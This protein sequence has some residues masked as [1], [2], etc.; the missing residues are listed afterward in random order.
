MTARGLGGRAAVVAAVLV[1]GG[2]ESQAGGVERKSFGT[3]PLG[4]TV[5]LF[6][7]KNGKGVTATIMGWGGIVVSLTAPDREGRLADIVLGFDT[8]A[9]YLQAHPYFGALV[10][11]YGN[12]IAGG[13][14]RLDGEVH[15]LPKNN[16]ENTL[17]GG[18]ES[19]GKK[20]WSIREVPAADGAAL[21]LAYTSPDGEEGF[22]GTLKTRVTYTLTD[23]S[24]LRIDYE[25]TTDKPT[26]V[27][28]TNHSY[29]NLAGPGSGDILGHVL[30]IDADRFTPVGEGPHPHGR[31]ARRRGHAVRL[32]HPHPDRGPHRRPGP[33][34]PARGRVR[35][36]LRA[37]REGGHAAAC[38]PGE[39]APLRPRAGGA[40]H[41][42]GRPALHGQLPR[43]LRRRQGRAG[44][45]PA[46]GILPGDPALPGL[47]E[48]GRLSFHR[49]AARG[50]LPVDHRL[51]PDH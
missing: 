21:E 13:E 2:P 3:T 22:P 48:P 29:F 8:L 9:P 25:A 51:P 31:A 38:G 16:G 7:L 20:L 28:L 46:Y 15:H 1:L 14:F 35:P 41:R 12:R 24:E 30:R 43:R 10:G 19:F 50:H 4:E 17:H 37:E 40:H 27:N 42:A 44:L 39:R 36:Q 18:N 33:P 11:R 49:A 26:V 6:T 32:P 5:E 23:A 47:T 34:A 45:R